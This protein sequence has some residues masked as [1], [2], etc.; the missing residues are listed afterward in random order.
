MDNTQTIIDY[1]LKK[2]KDTPSP[3][4]PT[5]LRLSLKPMLF[6]MSNDIL[7]AKRRVFKYL[8]CVIS[9]SLLLNVSKFFEAY[10]QRQ[11]NEYRVRLSWLRRNLVYSAFTNWSR[12]LV[13]GILPL[14]FITFMYT[15]VYQRLSERKRNKFQRP[16]STTVRASSNGFQQ[17]GA[18]S[19]VSINIRQDSTL[20]EG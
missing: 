11:N 12:F 1:L 9:V 7:L 8:F 16:S 13:I 17:I 3:C 2:S 6:Q 15:K 20:R 5:F 14:V 10:I 18:I 4:L 19:V